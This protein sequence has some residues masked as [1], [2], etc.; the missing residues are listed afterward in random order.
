MK[1]FFIRRPFALLL[2]LASLTVLGAAAP[3]TQAVSTL[4]TLTDAFATTSE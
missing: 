2:A 3:A 1:R 4:P